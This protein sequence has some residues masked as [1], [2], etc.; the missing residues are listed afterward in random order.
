M[1]M[2]LPG[3]FQAGLWIGQIGTMREP[4]IHMIAIRDY[5]AKRFLEATREGEPVGNG[6]PDI[7][8]GFTGRRNLRQHQRPRGQHQLANESIVSREKLQQLGIGSSNTSN[9]STWASY[10]ESFA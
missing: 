4:E 7:V 10:P 8:H 2:R 3:P 1:A 6:I 5:I 9:L